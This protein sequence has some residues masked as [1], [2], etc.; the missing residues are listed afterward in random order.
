MK[1]RR[2]KTFDKTF[3]K[4]P[5]RIQI[6]A[7]KAIKLL[8]KDFFHPSLHTKKMSGQK[9][10]WEARADYKYRFTFTLENDTIILRV[11]GN[12]DEVLRN[13]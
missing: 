7:E 5:E 2:T 4:L 12:H 8:I 10:I 9:D 3:I 13:P 1:I 6:K 11:I